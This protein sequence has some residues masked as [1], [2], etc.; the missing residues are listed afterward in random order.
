M[1][2]TFVKHLERPQVADKHYRLN[3]KRMGE[4][5]SKQKKVH[6]FKVE[7]TVVLQVPRI[8]Q[9]ATD[10]YRLTCIVVQQISKKSLL[11]TGFE[12]SLVC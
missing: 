6:S 3:V 12:V 11:Y 10:L 9:V 1:L 7:D 5:Y 4:R 8:D 2:G